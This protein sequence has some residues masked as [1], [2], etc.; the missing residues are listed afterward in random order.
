M[1]PAPPAFSVII[2]ARDEAENIAPLL[3]ELE[4][5][6]AGCG[7]SWEV[8]VVDDGSTDGTDARLRDE[9]RQLEGRLRVLTFANHRGK[10]AALAA[11]IRASRGVLLGMMDAD[12]QNCPADFLPMLKILRDEPGV[13]F[14]QGCRHNRQDTPAKKMASRVGRS[15]RRIFL[16]DRFVDSGCG[17]RVMRRSTAEQLPLHW[18]GMHRFL[19][20]LAELNG[21]MVREIAIG[22]RPR[23]AGRSKYHIGPVSRGVCGFLDL[24]AVRWMV[25]RKRDTRAA[26]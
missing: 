26:D 15:M 9:A 22:H 6:L 16:G 7:F 2:P 25:W 1:N 23:H 18:E 21:G 12:L 4:E 8:I 17:L 11:G 14:L 20:F 5:V 13:T 10:S 24:L 19:P 3:K